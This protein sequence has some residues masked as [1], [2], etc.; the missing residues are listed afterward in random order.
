MS[1][2]TVV[3]PSVSPTELLSEQAPGVTREQTVFAI[4]AALSLSHLL[5]DLMQ[6]LIPAVYPVL[7]DKYSLTFTQI[8]FITFAFQV[9]A[10]LLQPLVGMVTDRRPWPFS[11]ATGMAF[12]FVGLILI[13]V[14]NSFPLILIAAALVGVGSSVFHPEASRVSR[15]ASGG[16]HGFAQSLF[17]V[18]G[19][20]GTALGP[21]LA[22]YIVVPRGQAS[23]AWFSIVALLAMAVLYGVGRWYRNH[24]AS[25]AARPK[26][27]AGPVTGLSQRRV[28]WSI[29]I[30]L[31]LVF[32]KYF[33]MASLTSYY[34]FYLIERFGV[35][36]DTAQ[37]Y[38]FLFLA[39][40]AVGT[41]A[42]GP[43]GDRIGFKRVIWGS[44]LG[45]LPFSI[46]L[47]HVGLFWTAVLSVPI[48]L[49][50]ASAFSAIIVYAQELLPSRVGMIAGLFFGFAF[51]IAG[52]G[53]AVLGRLADATSI[54]FVYQV[55]AYLPAIGLLTAFLPNL[56]RDQ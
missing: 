17:Q 16:R 35:P 52:V 39:A 26:K 43:I 31:V 2:E 5:N 45:V 51:G 12:T 11:L 29:A 41:I 36:V 20:G 8:G 1:T 37:L 56:K 32:S 47:P 28:A 21:L 34:T 13:S 46:V 54:I 40:V 10:S 23:I 19:N 18:G 48:G 33:Y 55:C 53:A 14:A 49:I 22:A 27:A 6:S 15:M 30:L 24:L 38:L 9:T 3:A 25:R 7:K 44:I 50:L 42:G 4:L